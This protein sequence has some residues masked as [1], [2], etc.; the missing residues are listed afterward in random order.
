LTNVLELYLGGNPIAPETCPLKQESICK[1]ER[2]N[3]WVRRV[4][5]NPKTLQRL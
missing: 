4:I 5:L 2:T 3:N 1:W